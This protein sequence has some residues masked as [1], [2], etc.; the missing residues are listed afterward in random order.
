[1]S[2]KNAGVWQSLAHENFHLSFRPSMKQKMACKTRPSSLD[3]SCLWP[4]CELA[5]A[6]SKIFG[7]ETRLK[8]FFSYPQKWARF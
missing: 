3:K 6:Q 1:M 8:T 7:T 2:R 5:N 4:K